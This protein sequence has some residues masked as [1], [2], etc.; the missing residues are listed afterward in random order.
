M[1]QTLSVSSTPGNRGDGS[2]EGAQ[3]YEGTD[4]KQK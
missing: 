4:G 2:A 3:V 1:S